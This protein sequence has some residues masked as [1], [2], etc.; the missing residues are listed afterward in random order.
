[1]LSLASFFCR[2]VSLSISKLNGS[3]RNRFTGSIADIPRAHGRQLKE[4]KNKYDPKTTK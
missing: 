3:F 4:D 2:F 1:M